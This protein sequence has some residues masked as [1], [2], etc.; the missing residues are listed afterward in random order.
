MQKKYTT[1]AEVAAATGLSPATVSRALNHPELVNEKTMEMLTTAIQENHFRLKGSSAR[2]RNKLYLICLK[3]IGNL[4]YRDII[5]GIHSSAN[6][7]EYHT[8]FYRDDLNNPENGDELV[9]LISNIPLNGVITCDVLPPELMQ[10]IA[11][12][13]PIVQCCELTS[14][15]YPFA[16]IDYRKAAFAVLD[17]IFS[18]GHQNIWM[19][20]SPKGQHASE[21]FHSAF[22][23]YMGRHGFP[24]PES[25]IVTLPSLNYKMAY[26]SIL[27]LLTSQEPPDAIFG[28]TDVYAMAALRAAQQ[29]GCRVPNDLTVTGFDDL[30][31]FTQASSPA[32]TSVHQ[33]LFQIGYTAAELLSEA[34]SSSQAMPPRKILLDTDLVIRETSFPSR[35]STGENLSDIMAVS[36]SL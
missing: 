34:M 32:I 8:L 19:V 28:T 33:P 36:N 12:R 4:F 13:V 23:E 27:Q 22:C 18:T 24:N 16:G 5:K 25:H 26:S 14:E 30:S 31:L 35:S 2:N 15:N 7:R 20:N 3:G 9:S 11:A 17:H 6:F 10:K 1:I 29:L 21:I